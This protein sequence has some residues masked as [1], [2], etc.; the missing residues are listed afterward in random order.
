MGDKQYDMIHRCK[1]CGGERI[2]RISC[3][4][5]PAAVRALVLQWQ[6]NIEVHE[7]GNYRWGVAEFVA[8]RLVTS[9]KGAG[10]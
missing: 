2:N 1:N 10:R 6:G 3:A 8:V 7:C 9:L 5:D 4:S